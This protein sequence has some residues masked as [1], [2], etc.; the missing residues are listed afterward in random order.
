LTGHIPSPPDARDWLVGAAPFLTREAAAGNIDNRVHC[1]PIV[2]QIA[3]N[4][5]GHS[6]AD[7]AYATAMAASAPIAR[8]SASFLYTGARM[9]AGGKGAALLDEGCMLRALYQFASTW[10]FVADNRWPEVPET[11]NMVPA[12]DCFAAGEGATLKAYYSIPAGAGMADTLEAAVRRGQFP[13]FAMTVDE[14]WERLGDGIW[15]GPDG[16]ALGGHAMFLCGYLD[17]IKAFLV[18][19][20]W[21]SDWGSF[22]YGLLAYDAID[23]YVS[24]AWVQTSEPRAVF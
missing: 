20:S 5:C 10:G 24:E 22:G 2:N 21:G 14:K 23:R 8:P 1:P 18:Q 4:C 19:N 6:S 12:D 3:N 15:D 17:D 16:P 9:Q 13:V 11:I 7:A